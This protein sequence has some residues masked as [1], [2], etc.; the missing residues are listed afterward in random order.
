MSASTKVSLVAAMIAGSLAKLDEAKKAADAEIKATIKGLV[1]Q[2]VLAFLYG[3]VPLTAKV[4]AVNFDERTAVLVQ[5]GEA[6][7]IPYKRIACLAGDSGQVASLTAAAE[8]WRT[9]K[10]APVSDESA[11]DEPENN[12][13]E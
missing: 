11:G 12:G 9:A 3:G 6:I 5:D 7:S 8:A 10:I 1:G 4:I 13:D 2:D